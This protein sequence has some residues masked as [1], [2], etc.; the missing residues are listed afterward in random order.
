MSPPGVAAFE[1][2]F[3]N[4]HDAQVGLR[5][6][7]RHSCLSAG[8]QSNHANP[9]RP[10]VCGRPRAIISELIRPSLEYSPPWRPSSIRASRVTSGNLPFVGRLMRRT[11]GSSARFAAAEGSSLNELVKSPCLFIAADDEDLRLQILERFFKD[12][13]ERL[14]N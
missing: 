4:R 7:V 12:I 3:E 14:S 13:R 11:T 10:L 6:R 5:H 1:R 9:S 2:G 8:T